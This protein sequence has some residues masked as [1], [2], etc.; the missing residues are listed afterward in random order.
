MYQYPDVLSSDNFLASTPKHGV[1]H[2]LPT[3]PGPPV[4]AKAQ[5]LDAL[6]LAFAKAEFLKMEKA[7]IVQRSSS[8]WSAVLS[9][10][11]LNLMGPGDLVVISV[12]STLPL[13]L[14]NILWPLLLIS[15]PG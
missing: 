4:F 12:N 13:F 2:D 15:P 11:Y 3:A 6:K 1:F 8:L 10:W 5:C 9:T 7:G 14:K